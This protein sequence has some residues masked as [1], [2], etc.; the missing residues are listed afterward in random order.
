MRFYINTE[1][2]R[3]EIEYPG[4]Y[5]SQ[6]LIKSSSLV[7]LVLVTFLLVFKPFGVYDP[8][9]KMHYF[10]ICF[11]HAFAPALILFIYFTTLNYFRKVK[12]HTQWTLLKEYIHIGVLLVFIGATSF[13][14]RDLLYTNSN[15]WSWHYLF[16]EIRNCF[17]AGIFFYFFLQLSSFY[18]ESKKGSSFVLQFIPLAVKSE[19]KVLIS[20]LFISTQV[21]QDD[22]FLDMDQL[23]FAKADGNYIELTKSNDLQ[24]TTEVKRISLT[25]FETQITDYPHLFR[26]HRTYLVNMFKIEQVSGNSQGYELSFKETNI[27]I[28]VSRKQIDNF[29]SCYQELRNKHIA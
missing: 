17:V 25:Q 12:N 1:H 28:P 2:L 19:K 23:L 8:E 13:L 26:C 20:N 18:F 10:F 4:R 16:E 11:L 21:K 27:K 24:M 7:F 22:F 5:K 3:N 29:N 15:N 9:L 6:N 14:M